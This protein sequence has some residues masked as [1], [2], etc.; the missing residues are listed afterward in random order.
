MLEISKMQKLLG[1]KSNEIQ[2]LFAKLSSTSKRAVPFSPSQNGKREMEEIRLMYE[3]EIKK[4]QF[5]LKKNKDLS[6]A[7]EKL[8]IDLEN[9]NVSYKKSLKDI[10][11][12][13]SLYKDLQRQYD[14]LVDEKNNEANQFN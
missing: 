13:K 8:K 5:Q 10:D 12:E 11:E 14:Y 3:N 2:E 4:Y 7:I 6:E 9:L 1:E